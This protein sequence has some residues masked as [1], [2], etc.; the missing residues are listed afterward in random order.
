[1]APMT[2]K[3]PTT[4]HGMQINLGGWA[5]VLA[6]IVA[7]VGGTWRIIALQDVRDPDIEAM[8]MDRL[9]L[10]LQ[11]R[12]ME[13]IAAGNGQI[14]EQ[15]P[16]TT[17]VSIGKSTPIL[18]WSNKQ[19]VIVRI[20]YKQTGSEQVRLVY[21]RIRERVVGKPEYLGESSRSSYLLRYFGS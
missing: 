12:Y 18:S 1:M 15:L 16:T 3:H 14:Q 7:I 21:M 2:R 8:V 11:A 4:H 5:A 20:R 19:E 17:I 9:N 6:I 13:T 10:P